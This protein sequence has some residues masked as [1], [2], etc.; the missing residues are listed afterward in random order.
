MKA[1]NFLKIE[2]D[3]FAKLKDKAPDNSIDIHDRYGFLNAVASISKVDT[4]SK[5]HS[6]KFNVGALAL[7]ADDPT[8]TLTKAFLDKIIAERG[9]SQ[10]RAPCAWQA[11]W[12]AWLF[13]A[14]RR[15]CGW[16]PSC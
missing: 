11:Y 13:W 5:I 12:G 6:I 3:D 15:Y 10:A 14:G 1:G 4:L 7:D 8:Y 2:A 16:A 9:R